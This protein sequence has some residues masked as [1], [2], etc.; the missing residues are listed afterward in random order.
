MKK[1]FV[2][3]TY[4]YEG[5][6][7]NQYDDLEEATNEYIRLLLDTGGEDPNILGLLFIGGTIIKQDGQV[8]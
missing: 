3:A 2:I 4:P 1:Y 6:T 5:S 7:V 8:Y